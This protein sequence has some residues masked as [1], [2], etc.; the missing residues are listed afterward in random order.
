MTARLE[1]YFRRHEAIRFAWLIVFRTGI[2]A[3]PSQWHLPLK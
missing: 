3:K 1:V 2:A